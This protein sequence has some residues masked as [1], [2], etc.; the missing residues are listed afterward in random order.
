MRSI[1]PTTVGGAVGDRFCANISSS[2]RGWLLAVSLL[3]GTI[4]RQL[5]RR[6]VSEFERPE[7]ISWVPTRWLLTIANPHFLSTTTKHRNGD[8]GDRV[9]IDELY[10]LLLR[11]GMRDPLVIAFGRDTHIIHPRNGAHEGLSLKHEILPGNG[12]VNVGDILPNVVDRTII[13]L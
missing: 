6:T 2:P 10:D 13:K 8:T 9:T 5:F 12:L 3:E 4:E 7:L 11:E 1:T